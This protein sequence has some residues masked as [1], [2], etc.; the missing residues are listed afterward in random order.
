MSYESN[1]VCIWLPAVLAVPAL[2]V[3]PAVGAWAASDENWAVAVP[4]FVLMCPLLFYTIWLR[5]HSRR[6]RVRAGV[7]PF[8]TDFAP[9]TEEEFV[10]A[11][12]SIQGLE[13]SK[14]GLVLKKIDIVGGGWGYFLKKRSV[15]TH[16]IFLHKFKGLTE[17]GRWRAGT[18]IEQVV[19]HYEGMKSK[20]NKKG[21]TVA[22]HPTMSYIS[23]GSW[24]AL[25]NHGNAGPNGLGNDEIMEDVRVLNL[26]TGEIEDKKW[27]HTEMRSHF[28]D[29][30]TR[31][32][33]AIVDIAFKPPVPNIW[34]QKQ[35]IRVDNKESAARWISNVKGGHPEDENVNRVYLRVLFLGGTY[36]RPFGVG[37]R[38]TNLRDV[39]ENI[40]HVDPH[41]CSRMSQFCQVDVCSVVCGLIENEKNFNGRT[42]R[43][44]ANRW[45]P[46]IFPIQNFV[47]LLGGVYNFEV[48][49]RMD[50]SGETLWSL[51]EELMKMH[52][53]VGGRSEI[54]YMGLGGTGFP[55]CLDMSLSKRHFRQFFQL[56][57]N[58]AGVRTVWLHLG[59]YQ[60]ESV[61]PCV[62][63]RSEEDLPPPTGES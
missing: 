7:L 48:Y 57:Y 27:K 13:S 55:L 16:R 49:F 37:I 21:L 6:V 5:D 59:K 22:S 56:L 34:I 39:K 20:E 30:S 9:K 62:L 29:P 36:L 44:N 43:S 8:G 50:V 52:R 38:W 47:V 3:F 63:A 15:G 18:T 19:R 40:K 25:G 45:V 14:N 54:R 28:D 58:K 1:Y 11:V 41:D 23:I 10:R 46:M 42:T 33:Y 17:Q 61:D 35:M 2:I 51:C 31:H 32:K 4:L 12:Q 26:E 60:V 53:K 24:F